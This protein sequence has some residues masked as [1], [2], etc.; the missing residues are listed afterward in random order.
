MI[1]MSDSHLEF[2]ADDFTTC[3]ILMRAV[4]ELRDILSSQFC[5]PIP[6]K[7]HQIQGLQQSIYNETFSNSA[8]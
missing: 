7:P 4:S 5:Q 1:G 6:D 2:I 8:Y 3:T